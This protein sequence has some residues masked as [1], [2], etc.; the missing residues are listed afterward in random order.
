MIR[1]EQI[2]LDLFKQ[3][4]IAQSEAHAILACVMSRHT[5]D[6]SFTIQYGTLAVETITELL[7]KVE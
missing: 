5:V 3:G 4:T 2:V 6:E 7:Q 1:I